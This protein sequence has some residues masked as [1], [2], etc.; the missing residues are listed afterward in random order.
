[1]S[2]AAQQGIHFN[3]NATS[4][5]Q[6]QNSSNVPQQNPPHQQNPQMHSNPTQ[7]PSQNQNGPASMG[8]PMMAN[9]QQMPGNQQSSMGNMMGGPAGMQHPVGMGGNMSGQMADSYTMSQSQT[10]NFTQQTLRQRAN[11]PNGKKLKL[12]KI[13]KF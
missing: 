7:H 3:S 8:N 6:A 10:I 9:N 1:M 12:T 2:V 13:L 5:G 11:G 4:G